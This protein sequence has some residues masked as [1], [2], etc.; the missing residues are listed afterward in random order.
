MKLLN[1]LPTKDI[2]NDLIIQ[3]LANNLSSTKQVKAEAFI[4]QNVFDTKYLSHVAKVMSY[5][6]VACYFTESFAAF[7]LDKAAVAATDPLLKFCK[8]H[9]GKFIGLAGIGTAIISD[10]DMRTRAVRAGIGCGCASAV[11]LGVMA[12]I[13]K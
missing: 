4:L 10:G 12:A 9:W 6:L 1:I 7:D 2:N 13:G 5:L 11:V 3:D 8:D